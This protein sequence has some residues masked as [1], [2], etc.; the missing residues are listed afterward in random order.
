MNRKQ[1]QS[2]V[3]RMEPVEV[4][5]S[6]VR[7]TDPVI[8]KMLIREKAKNTLGMRHEF[9]LAEGYDVPSEIPSWV[10]DLHYFENC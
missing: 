2:A 7:R 4:V 6:T 10:K 8:G 9:M 1:K 5:G 3:G